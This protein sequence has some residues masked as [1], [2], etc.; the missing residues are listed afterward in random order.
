VLVK[1]NM[2]RT[3][4]TLES[5]FFVSAGS[6][7]LIVSSLLS[8]VRQH[9]HSLD[10]RTSY[11]LDHSPVALL[12]VGMLF[13]GIGLLYRILT[14]STLLDK[15]RTFYCVLAI[16]AAY[17][18]FWA[19]LVIAGG[20]VQDDWTL[21]AASSIR[22]ILFLH[23]TYVWSTLDTIDGNF[24][25]LGTVF[26]FGIMLRLFGLNPVAFLTG[27]FIL[28]LASCVIAFFI[29]RYLGYSKTAAMAAAILYLSRSIMYTQNAW[30][31][32]I[33]DTFSILLCGTSVLAVLA[34]CRKK[35]GAAFVFHVL[36]WSCFFTAALAKQSAFALPTI[37]ALLILIAPGKTAAATL[38]RRV[39]YALCTFLAYSATAAVLF[40][41]A[42]TL[43]Q[44]RTPY[45]IQIGTGGLLHL[46]CYVKWYFCSLELPARY[47]IPDT[48]PE[49]AGA[50]T[51]FCIAVLIF[52]V[53]RV[54]GPKPRDIVFLVLAAV[55]SISMFA[56]LNTRTLPYY[57]SM[58]AFWISIAL[59]I[60]LTNFGTWSKNNTPG[61]ICAFVF[62]CLL[63]SGFA[64]V[65]FKQTGLLPS[66]G[67]I[68]GTYG[69]DLE[70]SEFQKLS[71]LL[72]NSPKEDTLVLSGFP[73]AHNTPSQYTSMA[74]LAD[75]NIENIFV[76]DSAQNVYLSNDIHGERPKDEFSAL[77]DPDAFRWQNPVSLTEFNARASCA[78][79]L[80]IEDDNGNIR[81]LGCS[82][83][84]VR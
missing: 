36:A 70:R 19:P 18:I 23:P 76:F 56:L 71:E 72:R 41:H 82:F 31:G 33:N 42:R 69:M 21:L 43:L 4:M 35:G 50:A 81:S 59:G 66:G 52:R 68:R 78:R 65:R 57:G 3:K 64:E 12:A 44:N 77:S 26:Y 53:P 63:A 62:F 67:Y 47:G 45:P 79:T 5:I 80:W 7:C 24:R 1:E 20:F 60:C 49:I 51:I 84:S 11:G 38:A 22:R 25:P 14:D 16:A 46:L 30:A 9:L 40:F 10:P 27:S 17:G 61:R 28:N 13:I 48:I 32:E 34:A 83:K 39:L 29:V 74:L 2:N 6:L 8:T 55:A 54:L 15:T 37:V 73:P 75:P 58:F